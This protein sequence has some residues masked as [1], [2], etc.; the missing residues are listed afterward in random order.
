MDYDTLKVPIA[1]TVGN[2]SHV[3]KYTLIFFSKDYLNYTPVATSSPP[4]KSGCLA[5]FVYRKSSCTA[6]LDYTYIVALVATYTLRFCSA[7]LSSCLK[8]FLK[9][10]SWTTRRPAAKKMAK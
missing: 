4:V 6:Q 1:S 8:A 5:T 9:E 2:F 10:M 7:R 3:C